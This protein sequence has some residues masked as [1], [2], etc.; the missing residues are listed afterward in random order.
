M[1]DSIHRHNHS[2]NTNVQVTEKRAPTDESVRLL[3]EL[4][5]A[6]QAKIVS[7]IRVAD[8]AFE[9]VIHTMREPIN[10]QTKVCVIFSLNG[11]K[12]EA[13]TEISPYKSLQENIEQVI[14]CVADQIAVEILMKTMTSEIFKGF[15]K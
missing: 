3:K 2:Y 15:A 13:R 11:K 10:D 5:A 9:C 8:T 6:A 7:A 1:F 4:E 14:K 12:C